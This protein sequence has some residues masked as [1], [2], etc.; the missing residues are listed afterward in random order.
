MYEVDFLPVEASGGPSSKSGDAIALRFTRAID[1]SQLVIV[2]DA[3][4]TAVGQD[5]VDHIAR[6]YQSNRVDLM[7]ST[8][9]D[10]DH[11]N[12][13]QTVV[14]QLDVGELLIHQPRLHAPTVRDFANIEA[15]DSLVT[16]AKANGTAVTEPFAGLSRFEGQV[17][18]LG[19][20]VSFYE[21]KLKEHLAEA[22]EGRGAAAAARKALSVAAAG[23][24][25]LTRVMSGYPA[26]TLGED[27]VTSARNETSVVTLIQC[28]ERRL[29]FTGD[30][31]LEGLGDA[32]SGYEEHTG[33][34][35]QFPLHMLHVPH[36][37]SRR[38]LS[39]TLLDRMIG[40]KEAG[41]NATTAIVSS[42]KSDP[43]HPS[44][45]VMNALGRRGAHPVATEGKGICHYFDAPSRPG[46]S[47]VST[48]P[49]LVED[50]D[51]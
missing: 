10:T 17:R 19:P 9:P 5:V 7:I 23:W 42:A 14:E 50:D 37:G 43:K 41:F 48:V 40:T 1:G 49:P 46:W 12:G 11:L 38:N 35:Q 39:P 32:V 33:P 34:F 30:A 18:V 16:A 4:F 36:H 24:D 13:L 26:E 28:D 31:G 6:H 44:P 25:L 20:T 51:D 29:L 27:G 2:I 45:K 3:G 21:R 8:H 22:G 15:V 47:P